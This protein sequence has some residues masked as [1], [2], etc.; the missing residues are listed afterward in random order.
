MSTRSLAR[1]THV[2]SIFD[3]FFKPF[4]QWFDDGGMVRR[5]TDLPAV[6]IKENGDHYAVS[7]AA[8][9]MKKED[10]KIELDGTLLTISAERSNQLEENNDE[11]FTRKEFSYESF[12]RSFTLPKE[13]VDADKLKAVYENGV[14]RLQVPKKEEAK[15]KPPKMIAIS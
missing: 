5:V 8:P 15:Q 2:P 4:S 1:Q 13:V 10:F 7:V 3:D 12:R 9:G 6:N 11:R 14:L